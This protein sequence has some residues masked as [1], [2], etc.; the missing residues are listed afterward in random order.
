[1][2][3]FGLHSADIFKAGVIAVPA[4][5]GLILL[6]TNAAV[7]IALINHSVKG[8]LGPGLGVRT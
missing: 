4:D 3:P 1:M 7:R 2:N 6:S 5:Y 8:D